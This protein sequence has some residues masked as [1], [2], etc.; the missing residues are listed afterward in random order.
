MIGK[1][2]LAALL[3][4]G[5]TAGSRAIDDT[6]VVTLKP[7]A[8]APDFNL[9]GVDGKNWKL[10]DFAKAKILVVIFTCVHCPTAQYYEERI[11][12][13]VTDYKDKGVAVVAI[14]PNDPDSV[15]PDEKGY[16]D[17]GDSL[18][19]MKIRARDRQFNFP[20]LMGGGE[21]EAVAKA[22][23]AKATPHT[24]IFDADRKLQYVG[25]IDDS[26]RLKF[27]RVSDV[28]NAL[29]A[30]LAGKEVA[31]KEN[32]VFGCSVK[33]SSKGE[34]MKKYWAKLDA[35]PI[36]I[37][38]IDAEGMRRLRMNTGV[39]DRSKL[40]LINFWA[41]WCGPCVSEFPDIQEIHRWYRQRDF[42]VV[43][44]AAHFP[45]E[46]DEALAFLKKQ[47]AVTRNLLFGETDKYKLLEAFEP[48][49]EGALPY[50]MLIDPSGEVLYK[51]QGTIDVL[52]VKR[53]I[54]KYLNERKPW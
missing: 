6:E 4:F 10:S 42:E 14:S 33:W 46:K 39:N 28:R 9:P 16:T 48:G 18:E 24:Y 54:V 31:V 32:R 51:T 34:E 36:T 2:L 52:K 49:W 50:T 7:G 40:R 25:R 45:D 41:T 13:L 23:G 21:Y 53:L 19:E 12:Q 27:V 37:E 29:D 5:S 43:T 20:F 11:K 1:L 15:R 17:L 44:V 38:P 8:A 47:K 22:Y 26:E 3:L 35:E 30:L